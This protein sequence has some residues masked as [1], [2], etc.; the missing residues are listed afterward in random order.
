MLRTG[1][2]IYCLMNLQDILIGLHEHD[3]ALASGAAVFFLLSGVMTVM[4]LRRERRD[5]PGGRR[6]PA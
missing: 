6:K 4:L 5:A 2:L 1:L 3:K